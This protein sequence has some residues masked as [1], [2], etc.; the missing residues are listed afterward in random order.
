MLRFFKIVGILLV[1]LLGILIF[2]AV[3]YTPVENAPLKPMTLIQP[4]ANALAA[5]LS[6]AITFQTISWESGNPDDYAS[7]IAL[8]QWLETTYPNVFAQLELT[9]IN[10]HTLLLRWQGSEATGQPVLFSAHYDVVPVNPGTENEWTHSPFAG[11]IADNYVWGRGAL[12]DKSAVVGLMA[13][14]SGLLKTGFTPKQDIYVALTHDEELGSE[15]GAV[16]LTQWFRDQS[17]TPAWSLDEGS[18]VLDGIVPGVDKGIAS[19]NVSEKGYL[20]LKLIAH[21]EGGHSSM[22]PENTAV[23]VLAEAL[24]KLKDAPLPGGLEGISEKM[25]GDIARNMDFSKRLLFANLWLF[26]P[27]LSSVLDDTKSGNAMMRTTTAPTM[28]S[29]SVKSN[30]L[31]AT[32]TATINFRLH[33]RDTVEDVV[34]WVTAAIDDE[35]IDVK[36]GEFTEASPVAATDNDGFTQLVQTT[37]AVYPNTI[38]TPGLTI[39]A[40]D[41][42]FYGDI[43]NAYR[44][45]PM[46]INNDDL[47]GFH[48]TNERISIEN[49]VRA[50]QFYTAL[51][52]QQ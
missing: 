31:P 15:D 51:M 49:L 11:D 41:S 38:I 40:T 20:T 1:G 47:E 46:V 36:M 33:P 42:R 35:R 28:L 32:A 45:N 4:D 24:V 17:I 21:G 52:Q 43:T 50:T 39:A 12:D 6:E 8:Q 26:K 23:T 3:R 34:N 19:I 13:S 18:F 30:V 37:R 7:F 2:N 5:Q 29:G 9:R 14:V 44:F 48:G 22:P 25:Y 10:T 27:L 16:A